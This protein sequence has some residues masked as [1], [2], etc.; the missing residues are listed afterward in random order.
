MWETTHLME[1]MRE[2]DR[3]VVEDKTTLELFK[4]PLGHTMAH[5]IVYHPLRII[6]STMAEE[7]AEIVLMVATTI[8][9][10]TNKRVQTPGI[11]LFMD[12]IILTNST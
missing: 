5:L 2:M 1:V 10:Q 12:Q 9:T 3:Q 11:Q 6:S 7:N 4:L 8:S